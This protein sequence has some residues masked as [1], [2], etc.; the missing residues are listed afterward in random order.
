MLAGE[1]DIARAEHLPEGGIA[2]ISGRLFQAGAWGD[3]D[4]DDLEFNVEI[5]ADGLAVGGPGVGSG[6]QAVVDMDGAQ[7]GG[8]VVAGV[9]G[10]QVQEDGGIEA[11]GEGDVPG[12][13]V[14]PRSEVDHL[15]LARFQKAFA[16]MPA[17]TRTAQASRAA[18][19][20]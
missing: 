18:Q 11:A 8:C 19:Y 20:L 12:G 14:E 1:Q 4:V 5:V 6:L 16:G 15:A 9:F 7:R 13:G 17:P 2:R 3:L 10:Q